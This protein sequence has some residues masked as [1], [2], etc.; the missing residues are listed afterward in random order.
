VCVWLNCWGLC[1]DGGMKVWGSYGY[2]GNVWLCLGKEGRTMGRISLVLWVMCGWMCSTRT[3][4]RSAILS[5]RLG[6]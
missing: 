1:S 5:F 2:M 6:S 3:M 4:L